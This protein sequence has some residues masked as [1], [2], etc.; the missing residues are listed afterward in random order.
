M[1]YPLSDFNKTGVAWPLELS[2]KFE[3]SYL[4]KKY[5][6]FQQNA[7]KHFGKK[8]SI[9]P[10]L[11]SKFFDTIAFSDDIINN[12]KNLIGENLYLWSSAFF[13]KAP[14]EGKIVSYHQDNPYWQL[15]TT[16]VVTVWIAL[17]NS[18]GPSGALELVPNSH[19]FGIINKLD[20]ANPRVSYLNG[21]KTTPENDLLSYK[22]NLT[23][24]LKK[25]SPKIVELKSGH[26]SIHHV[27]TVHGSGVN[28]TDNHRIGFA[29]RYISSDTEHTEE[30]KD[31][32]IHVCGKKNSYFIEEKRPK[33]EFDD[34]AIKAYELAMQ[35]A[36]AFGNKKY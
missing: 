9:K 5:F 24:F 17:T 35:A 31:S 14:G 20:V 29:L 2:A 8:I 34:E 10:N 4:E 13:C 28:K 25:H 6:E 7:F 27:N 16:N 22:Q 36:G 30:A 19:N 33:A 15:T 3:E 21:E 23:E 1:K 12:V 18:D 32:A 26:Y 11:L